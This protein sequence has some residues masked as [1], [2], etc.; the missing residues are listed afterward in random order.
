ML[1]LQISK[2][3]RALAGPVVADRFDDELL[4]MEL[5]PARMLSVYG[6]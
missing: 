2:L 1:I 3:E 5:P 6:G 4:R